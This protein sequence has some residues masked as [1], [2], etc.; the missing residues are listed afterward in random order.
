MGCE[1]GPVCHLGEF[2]EMCTPV[3]CFD[4]MSLQAQ[5]P[6]MALCREAH[7][8]LNSCPTTAP[9]FTA[10]DYWFSLISDFPPP[11]NLPFQSGQPELLGQFLLCALAHSLLTS[12]LPTNLEDAFL[13]FPLSLL[14]FPNSSPTL[15]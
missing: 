2:I 10:P 7:G 1:G 8:D 6:V 12:G 4:L 3:G 14:C 9:P 5:K 15:L 11:V 13:H